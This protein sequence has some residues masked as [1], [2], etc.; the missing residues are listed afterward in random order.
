MYMSRLDCRLGSTRRGAWLPPESVG[1][2]ASWEF[3]RDSVEL[4]GVCLREVFAVVSTFS[5]VFFTCGLVCR[6]RKSVVW[7]RLRRR[8]GREHHQSHPSHRDRHCCVFLG[9]LKL[10]GSH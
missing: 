7:C 4:C 9:R 5:V 10:A 6:S 1:V 2:G 8:A 3:A